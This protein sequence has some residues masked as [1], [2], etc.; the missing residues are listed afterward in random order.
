MEDNKD[1]LRC[2]KCDTP[3][4]IEIHIE[5]ELVRVYTSEDLLDLIEKAA[6]FE[7]LKKLDKSVW[8]QKTS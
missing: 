8:F 5:N 7:K 4:K 1:L 6:T 3:L 2:H